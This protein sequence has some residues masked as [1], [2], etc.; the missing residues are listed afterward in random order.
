[1]Q[2][3][4]LDS[5]CA[6]MPFKIDFHPRIENCLSLSYE[7][8]TKFDDMKKGNQKNNNNNKK[9]FKPKKYEIKDD[10]EREAKARNEEKER[11]KKEKQ[12]HL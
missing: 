5:M 11:I 4:T 12:T 10:Q 7:P 6:H 1:M 9:H 2:S 8:I 3:F